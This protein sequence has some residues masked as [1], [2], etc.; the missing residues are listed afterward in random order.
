MCTIEIHNNKH[1]ERCELACHV[2]INHAWHGSPKTGLPWRRDRWRQNKGTVLTIMNIQA[3]TQLNTDIS[4][5]N[6]KNYQY[7]AGNVFW[8]IT[9]HGQPRKM[10]RCL[11]GCWVPCWP[12]IPK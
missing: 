3:D 8:F 10:C 6:F 12:L 9:R 2:K 7:G 11:V 1:Q 5:L 4:T